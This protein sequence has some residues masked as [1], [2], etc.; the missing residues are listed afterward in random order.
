MTMRISHKIWWMVLW[1]PLLLAACG[2]FDVGQIVGPA[3]GATATPAPALTIITDDGPTP[4]P[5]AM[6]ETP[7][8]MCTPPACAPGEGYA[9]PGG[10][11]PGGCGTVCVAPTAVSGP[12][13][14]APTEWENL[15]SWLATLWRGNMNPAAVRAA[16]QQSGMQ[17]S[18]DD[19]RAADFDGDLLDEWVVVLYDQSLPGVPFGSPG[20]LWVV[21]GDGVIF[22][23]YTAPSSDIYEFLAPTIIAVADMTG[24][25][26]PE[27]IADAPTCGAHTCFNNYRII[28]LLD[29]Q[30]TDRQ[31]VVPQPSP[32]EVDPTRPTPITM[33]FAD[34][35]LQD[36]NGDGLPEFLVHGGNIGSVGAGIVRP[37]TEVWGWD[38]TAV[39]LRET[40]LDPTTSRHHILYEAND[41]MDA[42]DLDGALALYEM[43]INDGALGDDGFAHSPEQARADISAFAA[44]RLILIDLL[45][46][47]VE[48]A[49]S[50]LAWL[51]ATYPASAA[52]GAA[53]T[54]VAEWAGPENAGALCDRIETGL[55]AVANPAGALGDMGYG[56]PSLGADDFCH[57]LRGNE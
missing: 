10:D 38:G 35:R 15:E 4:T 51:G 2:G 30:L 55:S 44:F 29:G 31:F 24:D 46:G 5:A 11:C 27:L 13:A 9:C 42:G 3:G 32:V 54:L 45:Q 49:N 12:L 53:A 56:N 40:I 26:L 6:D 43:V 22:R 50:R 19:W 14:A 37:R 47:N 28:G 36:V 1:L 33:S 39:V 52:A 18:P 48:R 20:D 8:L 41:L 34:T 7:Q 16:L 17:R 23:Y 21:N 57:N 25:G